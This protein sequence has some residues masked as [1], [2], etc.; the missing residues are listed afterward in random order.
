L[1]LI[2]LPALR[3]P[4]FLLTAGVLLLG[5]GLV[6]PELSVVLAQAAVLGIVLVAVARLL[7]HA[8]ARGDAGE[9]AVLGRSQFADTKTTELKYPRGEGSSRVAT[10]SAPVAIQMPSAEPKS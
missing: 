4:A 10:G 2:Y 8:V 5:L 3:H 7:R 6:R 9:P 1:L